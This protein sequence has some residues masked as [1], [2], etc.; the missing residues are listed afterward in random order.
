VIGAL[1]FGGN[2]ANWA[3][4]RTEDRAWTVDVLGRIHRKVDGKYVVDPDFR[5]EVYKG[6]TTAGKPEFQFHY[7]PKQIPASGD[8][9]TERTLTR[10][11]RQHMKEQ[12]EK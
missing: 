2:S 4:Y 8:K 6:E 11:V 12:G 1:K 10:V 3:W 9:L 5:I 7:K